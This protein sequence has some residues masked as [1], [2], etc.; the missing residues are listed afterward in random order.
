MG[1][2]AVG[3]VVRNRVGV[4][5]RYYDICLAPKQFSCWNENDPNYSILIEL[6]EGI[7]FADPIGNAALEQCLFLAR[8]IVDGHLIDITHGATNYMTEHLYAS[9]NRPAWANGAKNIHQFDKQ[10]FF[11]A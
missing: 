10:V 1:Q 4:D 5:K 9:D 8:G 3:C 11:N 2:I 7:V 6:A